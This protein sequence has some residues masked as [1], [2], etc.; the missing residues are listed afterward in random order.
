MKTKCV[1]IITRCKAKQHDE[2]YTLI[3][4]C[5][6]EQKEKRGAEWCENRIGTKT[7]KFLGDLECGKPVDAPGDLGWFGFLWEAVLEFAMF[8]NGIL[9]SE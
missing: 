6:G 2:K 4:I 3:R 1:D 5:D 9:S 7:V 8:Y